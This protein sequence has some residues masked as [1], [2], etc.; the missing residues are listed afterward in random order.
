MADYIKKIRTASGDKQIDYNAL[1]NKPDLTKMATK[2]DLAAA[3]LGSIAIYTHIV[4]LLI[5]S[6]DNKNHAYIDFPYV[7]DRQKVDTYDFRSKF[8]NGTRFTGHGYV[9]KGNS[10]S[11]TLTKYISA[12]QY[13]DSSQ[14]ATLY[15]SELMQDSSVDTEEMGVS[16]IEFRTIQSISLG[17]DV[18]VGH[19]YTN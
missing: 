12:I 3:Q 18:Y 11:T 8:V 4:R 1:A 16:T 17:G 19:I 14:K 7:C 13:D 9:Y 2:E 15:F 6:A 5:S 10:V